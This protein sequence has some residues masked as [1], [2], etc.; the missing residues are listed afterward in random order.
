MLPGDFPTWKIVYYYFSTWKKKLI[1]EE[2]HE[3]LVM[4]IRKSVG[5]DEDP[6][7]GIIDAQSV[8]NTLVSSENQGFD[9]GKNKRDKTAYYCRYIR[10]DTGSCNTKCICTRSGRCTNCNKKDE[11]NLDKGHQNFC[12][13]WLYRNFD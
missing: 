3:V 12:R 13:W 11:G 9:A 10:L 2:I 4:K 8:K 5:K 6:S 1:W 7:V